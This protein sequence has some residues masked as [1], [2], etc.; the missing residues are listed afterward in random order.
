LPPEITVISHNRRLFDAIQS[1][2]NLNR[3]VLRF[4][5]TCAVLP[6]SEV[7][8]RSSLIILDMAAETRESLSSSA[9]I[10]E[11]ARQW[12][13]PVLA[14]I[15]PDREDLR[16]ELFRMGIFDYLTLPLDKFE[17]AIRIRNALKFRLHRPGEERNKFEQPAAEI[18]STLFTAAL[19]QMADAPFNFSQM[20]FVRRLITELRRRTRAALVLYLQPT[21]SEKFEVS[22]SSPDDPSIAAPLTQVPQ[23]VPNDA[24]SRPQKVVI[25]E[26]RKETEAFFSELGALYPGPFSRVLL[27]PVIDSGRTTAVVL[28]GFAQNYRIRPEHLEFLEAAIQLIR[29][30]IQFLR[31]K[32]SIQ[33]QL[34]SQ[35]WQFSFEF[36]DQIINQLA[37]GIVV[38]DKDL[39]IKYLNDA[40]THLLR[41]HRTEA[42][43]RFLSD[44]IPKDIISSILAPRESFSE[45]I[46]GPELEMVGPDGLKMLIGFS[47]Q[48]FRDE[49]SGEEGQII[50]F[51]DITRNREVQEEMRRMDRLASLGVMAS[52]IAHEIRNPLAGIKAIAQTFQEEMSE[53]DSKN[54]YVTRIIR[55]V[56]R[57]DEMLR[58]LFSYAKPHRPNRRFCSVS[59]IIQDV[60]TLL[61]QKIISHNIRLVENI[62]PEL[63]EVFVDSSQLQQILINLLLNGIE[64][65]DKNGVLTIS[66][67]EVNA[68]YEN[69]REKAFY[70]KITEHPYLEIRIEDNGCGIPP[71]NFKKI[72]NPF[73]TTKSFGTGL[74][75]SIVYQI[76]KE[77]D[78]VIYFDSVPGEGTRCYLFVPAFNGA[79]ASPVTQTEGV[80]ERENTPR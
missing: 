66:A 8:T 64:A 76:V 72:F 18:S 28:L 62:A 73:F 13:I 15:D 48:K 34:D 21:E 26:K 1:R 53:S 41:V 36:L 78:G 12:D 37:F 75:L 29:L 42:Q 71:D 47:V 60:V 61:R 56:N 14:F 74:G 25:L 2:L 68:A 58:A 7:L 24:A 69:F 43:F 33:E 54:E 5:Q 55:Q 16:T 20:K 31:I 59:G 57:L 46:G 49:S 22:F 17:L 3:F 51:K 38:I 40:A 52:G 23:F 10:F 35:V 19:K 65:I 4:C 77:N 50:S 27:H 9:K 39:R 6:Q 79:A 11:S 30:S 67:R 80:P 63:P 45:E 70:R 44:F 32:K